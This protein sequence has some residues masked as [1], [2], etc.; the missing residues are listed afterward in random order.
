VSLSPT[1][2]DERHETHAYSCQRCGH[3]HLTS[4]PR[5]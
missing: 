5:L 4:G 1:T 2:F 3:W